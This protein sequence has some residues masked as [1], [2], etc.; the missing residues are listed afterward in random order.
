MEVIRRIAG[1]VKMNVAKKVVQ[2][3]PGSLQ[4]CAGQDAGAEA[5]NRAI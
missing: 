3:A 2:Q 4:V 1:K 5:A